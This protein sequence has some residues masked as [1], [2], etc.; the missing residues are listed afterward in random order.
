MPCCYVIL[1]EWPFYYF[2]ICQCMRTT[3]C[4]NGTVQ[5]TFLLVMR[6]S[7]TIIMIRDSLVVIL[8]P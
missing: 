3:A 6:L 7:I 2:V 5:F 8:V 4:D 1:T